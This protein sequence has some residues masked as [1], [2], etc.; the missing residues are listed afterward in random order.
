MGLKIVEF[1]DGTYGLQ[2]ITFWSKI[3]EP[4]MSIRSTN[5]ALAGN[6]RIDANAMVIFGQIAN[7]VNYLSMS[8]VSLKM[9]HNVRPALRRA[10]IN[11]T[12]V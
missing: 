7:I 12:K 8:R 2:K 5:V 6:A 10:R 9:A 3:F 1:Y 4:K 11:S